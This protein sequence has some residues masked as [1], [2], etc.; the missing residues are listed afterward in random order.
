MKVCSVIGKIS[1]WPYTAPDDARTAFVFEFV[2]CKALSTLK[3]PA[4]LV[5]KS[6]RGSST[7]LGTEA[8]AAK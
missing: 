7:D 8:L 3:V 4:L 5:S 6:Y 2:I 1:G